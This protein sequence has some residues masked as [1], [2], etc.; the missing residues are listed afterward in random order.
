MEG[1][2]SAL[3]QTSAHFFQ[4]CNTPKEIS[5]TPKVIPITPKVL[6]LT[7]TS[8]RK[9]KEKSTFLWFFTRLFVSLQH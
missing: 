1:F 4:I 7:P 2:F 6:T 3:D 8:A 9:N 5:N